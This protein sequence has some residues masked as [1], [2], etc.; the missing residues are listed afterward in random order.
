MCP[1]SLL[2]PCMP[3]D[4]LGPSGHPEKG[5]KFNSLPNLY[6][7]MQ[8]SLT[9]TAHIYLA[10]TSLFPNSSPSPTWTLALLK[11]KKQLALRAD[12]PAGGY[13]GEGR[14]HEGSPADASPAPGE[15]PGQQD[16]LG[17]AHC[18]CLSDNHL[19]EREKRPHQP[20]NRDEPPPG[21]WPCS[22][23]HGQ[24]PSP[25]GFLIRHMDLKW[26]LRSRVPILLGYTLH[27]LEEFVPT[28]TPLP[29]G[30]FFLFHSFI[31]LSSSSPFSSGKSNSFLIFA[32]LYNT[33]CYD[34]CHPKKKTYPQ[35][36]VS[37]ISPQYSTPGRH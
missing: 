3:V 23:P 15:A 36:A 26:L 30:S 18:L 22:R 27:Y 28:V 35:T 20:A 13:L 25:T 21:L 10:H 31:H 6:K 33:H 29:T 19:A 2:W 32:E 7:W 1:P 16:G 34:S 14:S 11:T 37:L 5:G 12:R 8:E 17:P 9:V 4:R 24:L